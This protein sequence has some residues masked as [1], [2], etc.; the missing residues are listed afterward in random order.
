MKPHPTMAKLLTRIE[1]YL[2]RHDIAP[3]RF[4]RLCGD[5]NLVSQ[6]RAGRKIGEVLHRKVRAQLRA[7]AA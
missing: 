1:A 3:S 4:G 7:L 5:Q 6:L 2:I